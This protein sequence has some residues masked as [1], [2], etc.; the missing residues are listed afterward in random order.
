[1]SFN[2]TVNDACADDSNSNSNNNNMIQH[3]SCIANLCVTN[4]TI[5][6]NQLI[7]KISFLSEHLEAVT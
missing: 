1:M 2:L 3:T 4:V 6:D 5:F 7:K